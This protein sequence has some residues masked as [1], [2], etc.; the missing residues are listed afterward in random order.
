M[1]SGDLMLFDNT[2]EDNM[3]ELVKHR[4]LLTVEKLRVVVQRTLFKKV[5]KIISADIEELHRMENGEAG[6]KKPRTHLLS[7][8]ALH[9][10]L[11]EY[12][13]PQ[14][15]NDDFLDETETECIVSALIANGY[16]KGYIAHTHKKIVMSQKDPFPIISK[17]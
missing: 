7:L 4:I 10:T 2:I 13:N 17:M 16:M 5:H 11:A 15:D 1:K 8:E 6:D 12:E 9:H 14:R 3:D